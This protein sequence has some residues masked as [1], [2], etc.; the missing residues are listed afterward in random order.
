MAE[1]LALFSSSASIL[2]LQFLA[3]EE[4]AAAAA[5]RAAAA[6]RRKDASQGGSLPRSASNKNRDLAHSARRISEG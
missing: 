4:E 5:V 1:S 2:S 6:S 3:D